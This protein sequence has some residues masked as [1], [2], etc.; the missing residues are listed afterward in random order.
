MPLGFQ[1]NVCPLKMHPGYFSIPFEGLWIG[2]GPGGGALYHLVS[3]SLTVFLG[4]LRAIHRAEMH[5][6]SDLVGL[7]YNLGPWFYLSPTQ[8]ATVAHG[9]TLALQQEALGQLSALQLDL[10]P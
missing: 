4:T 7:K 8:L 1:G 3:C 2:L 6:I 9:R 5:S 10:P